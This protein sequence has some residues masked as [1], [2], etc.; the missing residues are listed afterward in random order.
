MEE[1]FYL[2]IFKVREVRLEEGGRDVGVEGWERGCD[3]IW[4]IGRIRKR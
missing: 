4:E 1:K 3:F 2:R